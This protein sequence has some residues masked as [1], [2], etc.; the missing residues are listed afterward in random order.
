MVKVQSIAKI[1]WDHPSEASTKRG[2][3]KFLKKT[4][5]YV[6]TLTSQAL[7]TGKSSSLQLKKAGDS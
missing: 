6:V 5:C 3:S 4:V 7:T 2:T 1:L